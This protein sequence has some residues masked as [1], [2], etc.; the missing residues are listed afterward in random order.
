MLLVDGDPTRGQRRRSTDFPDALSPAR[1]P[2][3]V[4]KTRV[5]SIVY[6]AALGF[7]EEAPSPAQGRNLL[8]RVVV[9]CDVPRLMRS[10]RKRLASLRPTAACW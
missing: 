2:N 1:D 4:V 7:A 10:G 3:P 6:S 8:R 9:L 5:V